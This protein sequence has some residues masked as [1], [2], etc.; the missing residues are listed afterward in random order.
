M[1]LFL[2][3][4]YAVSYYATDVCKC[5]Y[6]LNNIINKIS[7][8]FAFTDFIGSYLIFCWLKY[9][10]FGIQSRGGVLYQYPLIF[11][12]HRLLKET[13]E[14]VREINDLSLIK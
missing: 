3:I 9:K 2:L 4:A 7:H 13:R 6:A 14:G 12:L 11:S 5:T 10:A 8:I 1:Y